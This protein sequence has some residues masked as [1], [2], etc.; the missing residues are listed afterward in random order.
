MAQA[1]KSAVTVGKSTSTRFSRRSVLLVAG[2]LLVVA[3]VL[4]VTNFVHQQAINKDRAALVTQAA[5]VLEL[6]NKNDLGR[7]VSQ[8]KQ[9]PGYQRDPDSLYVLT[10]YY[11]NMG[12]AANARVYYDKL[13]SVHKAKDSYSNA[14]LKYA[15]SLQSLKSSVEFQES[16]LK[17][18]QTNSNNI[19]PRPVKK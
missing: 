4:L 7:I 9:Q 12:D 16:A 5:A 15:R 14:K 3:I 18:A 6:E 10:I 11:L 17:E 1:S 8:I 2:L 13:A 19:S